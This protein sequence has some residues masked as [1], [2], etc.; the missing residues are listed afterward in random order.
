MEQIQAIALNV[1]AYI[2]GNMSA[3]GV[4]LG[5]LFAAAKMIS[6][7]KAVPVVSQIQLIFDSAAKLLFAFGNLFAKCAELLGN[8]LKSDG[9]LGKK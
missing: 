2:D 5:I 8:V 7:E 3:I 1:L 9:L 6:T 4:V